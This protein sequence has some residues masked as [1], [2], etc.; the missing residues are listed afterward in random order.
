SV[1][2]IVS[3]TQGGALISVTEPL[4]V[5]FSVQDATL[6]TV[7]AQLVSSIDGSTQVIATWEDVGSHTVTIDPHRLADGFY[8]LELVAQDLS[9]RTTRVAQP[10]EVAAPEK[11]NVLIRSTNDLSVT[12]DGVSIDFV[13]QYNSL[14]IERVG[15]LGSGWSLPLA[16]P[17]IAVSETGSDSNAH[18]RVAPWQEGTRIYL[19]LPTGERAGFTLVTQSLGDLDTRL[20]EPV[21]VP[22]AGVTFQ[23]A[24]TSTRL[25]QVGNSLYEFGTGLPY[26]PQL[27]VNTGRVVLQLTGTDGTRYDY[28]VKSGPTSATNGVPTAVYQLAKIVGPAGQTLVWTGSGLVAGNGERVSFTR[29]ADG[30]IT[31]LIGPDGQ[32]VRY[33]YDESGRLSRVVDAASAR[34]VEFAYS[35]TA[36]LLSQITSS[37]GSIGLYASYDEQGELLSTQPLAQPL[38]TG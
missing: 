35:S 10:L 8:R 7:E 33:Q 18:T 1:A 23:L 20:V 3:W 22:D 11:T 4:T 37:D 12:L 9:G 29:D 14:D 31:S 24:S 21:W 36:G 27:L 30:R 13:R 6:D 28:S 15:Q 19:T 2:P 26:N 38:P 25:Q 17:N 5:D 16:E 34:R 32:Q